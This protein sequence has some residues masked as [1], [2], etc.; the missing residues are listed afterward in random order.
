MN[1]Y[2][3]ALDRIEEAYYNLDNS[4]SAMKKIQ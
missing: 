3:E 2:K 4:M 1:D